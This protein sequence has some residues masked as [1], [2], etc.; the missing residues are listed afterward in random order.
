MPAGTLQQGKSYNYTFIINLDEIVLDATVEQW[1]ETAPD[2]N[3][4]VP[5]TP[6]DATKQN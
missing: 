3:I 4:D 6:D 5:Y 2:S 1:D